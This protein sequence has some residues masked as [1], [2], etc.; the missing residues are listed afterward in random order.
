MAKEDQAA[1]LKEVQTRFEKRVR[2]NEV[3]V[4]EHWKDQLDRIVAM[5]PEGIAALQLQVKKVS[6]MMANRIKTLKKDAK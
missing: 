3:A 4:I 2:E 5:K 6:E 1:F